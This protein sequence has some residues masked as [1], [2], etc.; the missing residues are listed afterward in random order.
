[1]LS[2]LMK[3]KS[4]SLLLGIILVGALASTTGIYLH[5]NVLFRGTIIYLSFEGGFYGIV[6]DTEERYDPINLPSEFQ[7]EGLRVYV[8][9]RRIHNAASVHMW[10][11]LIDI[12]SIR[13]L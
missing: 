4:K 10:G 6:S 2:L 7:E 11:E 3:V 5:N 8:I 13:Q 1:M 12:R 9:A